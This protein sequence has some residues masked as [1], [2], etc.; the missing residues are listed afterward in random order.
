MTGLPCQQD[1]PGKD[2]VPQKGHAVLHGLRLAGLTQSQ[3]SLLAQPAFRMLK[4]IGQGVLIRVKNDE[5][6]HVPS[7][8][9]AGLLLDPVIKPV[10]EEI[11]Q[12]LTGQGSDRQTM[13]EGLLKPVDDSLKSLQ[14]SLILK[15]P[16]QQLRQYLV[17]HAVEVPP[18][19]QFQ[20]PATAGS[21]M[22]HGRDSPQ[23]AASLPTGKTTFCGTSL[24]H[25]PSHIHQGVVSHT[26]S[27]MRCMDLALLRI[28]DDEPVKG[29]RGP[30]ANG[31][32][33]QQCLAVRLQLAE[34]FPA[35]CTRT[36]CT[37]RP[38]GLVDSKEHVLQ[39]GHSLKYI[40]ISSHR[41]VAMVFTVERQ[42]A[43]KSSAYLAE[44]PVPRP[45]MRSIAALLSGRSFATLANCSFVAIA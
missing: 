24:K 16:V 14:E 36:T 11:G 19:I 8:T 20:E 35:I 25:W 1:S 3:T 34:K 7:I 6:I 12:I 45:L 32:T 37:T 4:N 29:L 39:G 38:T 13:S 30:I 31:Q 5:I 17:R 18:D 26:I 15:P 23:A 21:S 2:A 43:S 22:P 27:K 42:I 28:P 33:S 10:Q 41:A 44:R 40:P 9:R